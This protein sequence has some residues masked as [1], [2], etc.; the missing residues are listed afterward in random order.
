MTE[1]DVNT[2]EGKKNYN[3]FWGMTNREILQKIGTDAMRKGFCEDIWCKIMSLKLKPESFYIIP[4]VRFDDEAKLILD[5]YGIVF[6]VNRPGV[7]QI[8][9]ELKHDSEKGI[10]NNLVTYDIENNGSLE[11]LKEKLKEALKDYTTKRIESRFD[12][13]VC[14]L[15]D[16]QAFDILKDLIIKENKIDTYFYCCPEHNLVS[17]EI[18]FGDIE[19][20]TE[21]SYNGEIY[22]VQQWKKDKSG[23]FVKIKDEDMFNLNELQLF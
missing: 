19:V 23:D 5:N 8:R 4:D 12:K 22:Q 1:E 14:H 15:K 7:N 20:D 6:R 11:D 3:S 2:S 21:I 10:S 16:K 17:I 9:E 18:L 13:I